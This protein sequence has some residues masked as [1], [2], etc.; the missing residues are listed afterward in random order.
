MRP[1]VFL[2][3]DDA[4]VRDA[5]TQLL[6]ADG[7]DVRSFG[8]ADDFLA[9]SDP[10]EP[11][12]LVLDVRL[13][14]TTGP[15]LQKRLA[16]RGATWPI[17]FLTGFGDVP[18]SVATLKDGA[19]DFLEKPARE[20][21]LLARVH[22]AL[23]LDAERRSRDASRNVARVRYKDLTPREQEVMALVAAGISNKEIARQ[24]K[25]SHRTVETHRARVMRKMGADS[26]LQL[27]KLA[28]SVRPRA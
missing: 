17:I 7:L 1:T 16:E 11:G 20:G 18:T 12:C 6:E 24:L 22:D 27:V 13:P 15:D 19:F 8:D 21:V 14:G 2:V 26:L 10:D 25:I 9:T 4:A 28:E 5:L 23:S 3:D